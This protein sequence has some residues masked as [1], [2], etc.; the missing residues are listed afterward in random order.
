VLVNLDLLPF[1]T[2]DALIVQY[3][4]LGVYKSD[5]E[6]YGLISRLLL[7]DILTKNRYTGEV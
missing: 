4:L 3:I 6:V 1:P 2:N 7:P 5:D